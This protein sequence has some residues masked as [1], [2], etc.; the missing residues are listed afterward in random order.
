MKLGQSLKMA[1]KSISTSMLRSFL[2]ML[3]VI[4]G[5][6]SVMIMVSYAKGQNMA[7]QQYYK[8]LGSNRVTVSASMDNPSFESV[9]SVLQRYCTK[10]YKN[11][12]AFTP[13]ETLYGLNVQYGI[14]TLISDNY[15]T[16]PT[17]YLGNEQF[18]LCKTIR[19]PK[20]EIFRRWILITFSRSV[21]W[22]LPRQK[23]SLG[24]P[25]LLTKKFVSMDTLLR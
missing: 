14:K 22:G 10:D 18:R 20:A 13:D 3:G 24:T 25:I 1:V 9:T 15:E 23:S 7:I 11:I 8:S 17:I 12:V 2:T 21:Y 19:C 16:Y 6:A 4:I 5:L